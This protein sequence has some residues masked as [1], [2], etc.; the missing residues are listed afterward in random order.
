VG[1]AAELPSGTYSEINLDHSS[2]FE[3]LM[4]F[5]ESYEGIPST[6]MDIEAWKGAGLGQI[7]VERGSFLKGIDL[8]DH[9]EFGI[10]S[11]DARAMAPVTR[12]L[13]EQCFLA[14]LDSG[15]DYRKQSVG[16]YT[17]GNSIDLTNVAKPDE[18]EPRGSFA[19]APSMVANR[20]SN[21]LDLLGPSIP[22]DT[23]CSSSMTALHLAAQAILLGDC[24]AAV[25]AGCQLNHRLIDWIAYSQG[26]VLSRDGKCKPFDASADGFARA[27]GCVAVV[28]KPLEDALRDH[29]HIYATIL[30]TA[31]NSTGSG[32]PPGAPVAEPQSQAMALAFERADRN[33]GDV[34]YVE[35]H[36]TGTAKGD[37]TEANWVGEHFQRPKELLI[38]SVK[39][40][41]GHTEIAAFLVSLSKVVSI[42]EHGIIPPNVNLSTPN[43]AIKWLQYNLRAPTSPVPLPSADQGKVSIAMASSGIGGSN[44]HVVLEAPPTAFSFEQNPASARKFRGPALVMAG[45][46]S[47]RSVSTVSD[48]ISGVL[49]S[50]PLSEYAATCTVLGRRSK[51]MNWRSF[52]VA[53]P[54][55][56]IQFS[57]PQYSGRD[58]NPLIFVFSGQGPQHEAMGRELFYASPVFR[59]SVLEMDAICLRTMNKSLVNDCGLFGSVS[60]S[61]NF[62]QVW[63]I[64]LTLP[65]IAMFQMALFDLLV[66]LGVRPDGILGHSAGETAVLY[67]S[68]AA[69]KAMAMEL[70]II[71]GRV[72]TALENS[73][74]TMAALSCSAQE[75]E[76]LLMQHRSAH[77]DAIV[78]LACLN[79]PSAVAISG[80]ER[81]IEHILDLAQTKGILGR[82]IRTCV[83]IHSSMMDAC[84]DQYRSEVEDLF[85][86]YP[87]HHAPKIC[88]Y[89][90]LTGSPFAG[91]FDAEYFWMNTRSQ[92]LFTPTVR[93]FTRVTTFVEI[94]PHPVLSSYLSELAAASSTVLS[95]AQ[96]PKAGC[97]ST[98]YRDI[99]Q[100]F[101]KLTVAG[102]NC[103]DFTLLNLA[104]CSESKTR[105]PAYPFLKKQFPLFPDATEPKY[106]HGP[107]NRSH[108]QLNHETHPT[109]SEH[110]IRGEPI[111][112]AAGFLE[113]ALEFG[114]T[115]LFNVHF[116]AILSLS[117][118]TPTPVSVGLDGSYWK[119]TSSVPEARAGKSTD[120]HISAYRSFHGDFAPNNYFLPSQIGEVILHQPSK[121]GY[122]PPHVY[123]YVKFIAWTPDSMHYDVTII[124]DLGK[125]LCTL[126][127]FVVAKHQISPDRRLSPPLHIAVQPFFPGPGTGDSPPFVSD[128]TQ[129]F[130]RN[131]REQFPIMEH[132]LHFDTQ[133][134]TSYKNLCSE[135][136][137]V[138]WVHSSQ[139]VAKPSPVESLVSR[140]A[141]LLN[142]FPYAAFEVSIPASCAPR[143]TD[144]P[145]MMVR[146]YEN[147]LPDSGIFDVVLSFGPPGLDIRP[148]IRD[149][150]DVLLP[151]GTLLLTEIGCPDHLD[152]YQAILRQVGYSVLHVACSPTRNPSHLSI[153][154]QKAFWKPAV[155]VQPALLD[156][157]PF[158]FNYELGGEMDLQWEFSGLNPTQ[159][160]DIWIVAREGLD[161][162]AGFSLARALRREYLFWNI[163]F[164]AFPSTFTEEMQMDSLR[165]LPLWVKEEPDIIISSLGDLFV[166]RLA[167]FFPNLQLET[168]QHSVGSSL[169]CDHAAVHIHH[170]SSCSNF[171]VLLASIIEVHPSV[172]TEYPPGSLII[173]LQN[174]PSKGRPH[175]DLRSTCIVPS[176][177]P[178]PTLIDYVPGLV[179]SIL[180]GMRG[181][182]RRPLSVLITHCDSVTGSTVCQ[183]YSREGLEYS[184][185][186][187]DVSLLDLSRMG[188]G[189]FD[190]IV[191]GY[192][193][194]I[195]VQVLRTL[196][197]SSGGK[198]FLWN[199]ELPR[200]LREDPC[201]IRDALLVGFAKHLQPVSSSVVGR[202]SPDFVADVL[203]QRDLDGAVFHPE[204][205]YVILGGIGSLGAAIA[206]FMTQKGAR[207]IVVT[208]R[209]GL[210]TLSKAKNRLVRRIFSYLQGIDS[211]DIRLEAVDAASPTAMRALFHSIN[212][213][214][215]GCFILTAMLTDRL[216]STL[217][218]DDFAT[219]FGSKTVALETLQKT[220]ETSA[221]EFVIA[222]SSVTSVFGTGGQANYCAANGALEQQMMALPNGFAFICP[223]IVDSA[224]FMSGGSQGSTRLKHLI[225]WSISIDDMLLSLDDAIGKYQKGARFDRYMPSLDWDTMDRTHGMPKLGAHLVPS[226]TRNIEVASEPVEV[227]A[228]RIIQSV[229]NIS[230][231]DF[232]SEVPLTAYGVDSLSAGRLSFA[233]RSIMEVT[234]LQLLADASLTDLVRKFGQPSSKATTIRDYH[235][236]GTERLDKV[237]Q[238]NTLLHKLL[239][240]MAY[241]PMDPTPVPARQASSGHTVLLTGS[242]GALGC[243]LLV[244]LLAS[245]MVQAVYALNRTSLCGVNVMDRQTAALQKQGLSPLVAQSKKLTLLVG[246]L[247]IDGFGIQPDVM[248]ELRTSVTWIIHNAWKV[249]FVPPLS[250]FENLVIGTKQLLEF[251][252]HSNLPIPAERHYLNANVIRVG[253]LTGSVNGSWDTSQWVPAL[254]QTGVSLGCLPDGNDVSVQTFPQ[255]RKK[256]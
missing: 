240:T 121:P 200:A 162:A 224:F 3:F 26:S 140:I 112:P 167:P 119:I 237:T 136:S 190:L 27:E 97:S 152:E 166:P 16:C 145:F 63:P 221:L 93:N 102:H 219:V 215:G 129:L 80:Q 76:S 19:G 52:A 127:D 151:G 169:D 98:E 18:Y 198:L 183:I 70:A 90:T 60:S 114:A 113:M 229:L 251:A 253:Q 23:A 29:D 160:L 67:A 196:L 214:I 49:E 101:G 132:H 61:F 148:M 116:R 243:H 1:I 209:S 254:V 91:P 246:D 55:S 15:I 128:K 216:F 58:V 227:Q 184:K 35:L 74:G 163:R 233:L 245:D 53:D 193:D 115:V 37:P 24:K 10:S 68:G 34:S 144:Q 50:A 38:G 226:H 105:L 46:L 39:G 170:I 155:S 96:R 217:G 17:S 165:T 118:Q 176:N 45:G 252:I 175:I 11:R 139:I 222:F 147:T 85:D 78:E 238:M 157:D 130:L 21:H 204:K 66:D 71:R 73:G 164:V 185:A 244:R 6:R 65:A 69:P 51:Q 56:S 135:L 92:V 206:L 82:K 230:E 43:P 4:S 255:S 210:G 188:C 107:I 171:S 36:A 173:G 250:A 179:I 133:R 13:L 117:M 28:I 208:S 223:G 211:L 141:E 134:S 88:T 89:S 199:V 86:R 161:S 8:F 218:D 77:R 5:G 14:L 106:Y 153:D 12:K 197:R 156:A 111:W 81:S 203:P 104:S 142:D 31:V 192:E 7:A 248:S 125:R 213:E 180:V 247:E 232:D 123:A 120:P 75:A 242:T 9:V 195:H 174:C 249:D 228:A 191:S 131:N 202:T 99:L 72:F 64:S 172:A 95:V 44:G 207:R 42:F 83:P 79:S 143:L 181:R 94:G 234:Q 124:D 84:R 20:V 236:S 108:L 194:K 59:N 182:D 103:V 186:R 177:P 235:D 205:T 32:G 137:C 212:G 41:I 187:E 25:V 231:A 87:G 2:F 33:P 100:F 47:P 57:T 109:L 146:R 158:V 22:V 256:N 159:E 30:G 149:C 225:E 54:G 189:A 122:F 178:F 40:N 126:L 154:A 48:G 241:H 168:Q 220:I 150:Y 239:D 62:P 138:I 110:V 201:S